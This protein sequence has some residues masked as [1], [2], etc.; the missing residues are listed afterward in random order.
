MNLSCIFQPTTTFSNQALILLVQFCSRRENNRKH[1]ANEQHFSVT[2]TENM[3]ASQKQRPQLF[4][5]TELVC[6]AAAAGALDGTDNAEDDRPH[7]LRASTILSVLAGEVEQQEENSERAVS[8]AE[9]EVRR[10]KEEFR[11]AIS[12]LELAV[13][14]C[15]EKDAQT[16]GQSRR[17]ASLDQTQHQSTTIALTK[18]KSKS[19]SSNAEQKLPAKQR[20]E[21]LIV[22]EDED[23]EEETDREERRKSLTA[24]KG[25]VVDL[26][27]T[28]DSQSPIASKES[29]RHGVEND[30]TQNMHNDDDNDEDDDVTH[31]S[32]QD[33]N[34]TPAR[35]QRNEDDS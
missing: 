18:S 8:A 26:N 13:H 27:E 9:A 24:D 15:A 6:S 31:E 28:M 14:A 11:R 17:Q 12:L 25:K 2:T 1:K 5:Q 10:A 30:D 32:T 33:H 7:R 20:E 35:R 29:D 22:D 23:E 19:G 4:S 16:E 21:V 3:A 34:I